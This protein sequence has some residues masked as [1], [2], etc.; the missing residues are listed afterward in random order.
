MKAAKWLRSVRRDEKLQG[1][2]EEQEI[3]LQFNLSQAPW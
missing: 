1:Y 3:Q 2:L